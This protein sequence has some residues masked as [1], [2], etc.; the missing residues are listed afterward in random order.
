MI[1]TVSPEQIP[2][3][4][5]MTIQPDT[6]KA[7]QSAWP[8]LLAGQGGQTVQSPLGLSDVDPSILSPGKQALVQETLDKLQAGRIAP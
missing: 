7:I 4:W 1:G 8:N 3:G 2:P 6:I 5:V